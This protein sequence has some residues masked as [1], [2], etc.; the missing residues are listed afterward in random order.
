M[1]RF[2][3]FVLF[4]SYVNAGPVITQEM[5]YDGMLNGVSGMFKEITGQNDQAHED[6]CKIEYEKLYARNSQNLKKVKEE[7]IK[8][9]E[10]ARVNNIQHEEMRIKH[11]EVRKNGKCSIMYHDYFKATNHEISQLRKENNHI[12]LQLSKKKINYTPLLKTTTVSYVKKE[13]RVS[14]SEREKAKEDLKIQMGF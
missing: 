12:K 9:R 7:N 6:N 10:M 3:L 14:L 13:E 2:M 5:I 8:L 1:K 4:V 11:I